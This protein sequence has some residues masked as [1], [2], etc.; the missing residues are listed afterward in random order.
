MWSRALTH[1]AFLSYDVLNMFHVTIRL[2]NGIGAIENRSQ[3]ACSE[4]SALSPSVYL[5]LATHT[6]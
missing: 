2:T 6:I 1:Y 5:S 4:K 3:T